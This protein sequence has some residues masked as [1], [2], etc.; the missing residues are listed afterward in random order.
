MTDGSDIGGPSGRIGGIVASNT[1]R[2][3]RLE[4]QADRTDGRLYRLEE[5][6]GRLS[7]QLTDLTEIVA[8][9]GG[10]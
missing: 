1:N 8:K 9:L 10:N 2:I 6:V 5:E 3:E 7:E 4:G